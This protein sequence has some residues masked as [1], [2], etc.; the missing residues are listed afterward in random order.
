MLSAGDT[1]AKFVTPR[2]QSSHGVASVTVAGPAGGEA[3]P[4]P[5]SATSATTTATIGL[6]TTSIVRQTVIGWR[7]KG[8]NL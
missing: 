7:Q 5:K 6:K 2:Q 4:C 3:Q 8:R 1:F